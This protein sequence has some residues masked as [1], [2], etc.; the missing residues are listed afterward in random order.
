MSSITKAWRRDQREEFLRRG[1]I[2]A[3]E[4]L[5]CPTAYCKGRRDGERKARQLQRE[6]ANLGGQPSPI[7]NYWVSPKE[8]ERDLTPVTLGHCV[9]G[10]LFD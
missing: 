4:F 2:S 10:R 7:R 5:F 8:M 3:F 1:Q 6:I 9:G